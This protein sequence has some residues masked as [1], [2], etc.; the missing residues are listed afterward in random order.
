MATS[1][2]QIRNYTGPALFSYGFR[3]FFLFGGIWAAVAMA[4]WSA[5]LAGHEVL[6]TAFAPVEWHIHE[7][8]YGDVPAIVCG[9]LLTAV[10]NWTGRLPMVGSPLAML[11]LVWLVG[12]VAIAISALIGL[13]PAA[14]IDLA[15]LV[16]VIVVIGREI[17][18][19]RNYRN[20]KV[21]LAGVVLLI[22]NALFHL[23]ALGQ[24][25]GGY[26]NRLGVA[27]TIVL[28]ALIGGRIIPSFTRN[29]LVKQGPGRL[30]QPFGK[31]DIGVIAMS[32]AALLCWVVVP[33]HWLVG[34]G[35]VLAAIANFARLARWAGERTPKEPLVLV[36]HVAYAFIPIGF[37]LLALARFAPQ[38]VGDTAAIH[39]WTAGAIGLMTLAVMT[40]ASLGHTGRGLTAGP[41]ITLIYGL[42][43][44]SV[45]ARV[46]AA[47]GVAPDLLLKA[48]SVAW[49]FGFAGFAA[50]FTPMLSRPRS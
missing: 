1:A 13:V 42:I 47:F 20:L 15:F 9:F 45:I 37:T 8:L 40:R 46:A 7:M 25:S 35:A 19:G 18:A 29:W 10:P 26:G 36:L 11:V 4:V 30:P 44:I 50:V 39:A 32:V 16:V 33:D 34:W 23:E 12:R 49:I 22:G 41:A 48:A 38:I 31:F 2:E 5:M 28:I 43:L 21:L 3:P 24:I 17:V 6:P 27:I 14:V